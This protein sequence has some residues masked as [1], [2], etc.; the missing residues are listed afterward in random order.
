MEFFAHTL[1]ESEPSLTG[2]GESWDWAEEN[3]F[4]NRARAEKVLKAHSMKW[5]EYVEDHPGL[6]Q[7][8]IDTK[9]LLGWMGY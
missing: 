9:E 5:D 2:N 6:D 7:S 4:I 8:K 3:P 1:K